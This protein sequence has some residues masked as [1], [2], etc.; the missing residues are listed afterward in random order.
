MA[1]TRPGVRTAARTPG[2]R[3]PATPRTED[4]SASSAGSCRGNRTSRSPTPP[5]TPNTRFA[6]TAIAAASSV[7]FSADS[8]SGSRTADMYAPRPLESASVNTATSGTTRNN[9]RKAS[10]IAVS[11]HRTATGSRLPVEAGVRGRVISSQC[12]SLRLL[13]PCSAFTANSSVKEI[14]S[15]TSAMAVA[16]A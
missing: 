5:H 16:P 4:R 11:S 15:I 2:R 7:S 6:G 3:S 8:A 1:R 14:S 12:A 13:Q 9:A 10:A